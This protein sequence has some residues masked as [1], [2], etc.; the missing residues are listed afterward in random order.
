[1]DGSLF[2]TLARSLANART[3]RGALATVLGATVGLFSR[4]DAD[5]KKGKGKKPKVN[6]FGCIDV[7]KACR[8]KNGKCCSGICQGKKPKKGK[9]DKSKCVAHNTGVC[10]ADTDTCTVGAPALCNPSNPNCLCTLTTG[11]AGFCGSFTGNGAGGINEC[12]VCRKDTD[13]QAEFGSGAACV[14]LGGICTSQ[15]LATGRTGCAV[16]CA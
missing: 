6:E 13:C 7:G 12:R 10:N 9:K 11:N 14:V 2:D 1:M 5:A 15:C 8:G 3:R 16:P 4:D